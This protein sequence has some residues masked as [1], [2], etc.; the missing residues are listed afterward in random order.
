MD[1][2]EQLRAFDAIRTVKKNRSKY[3]NQRPA[4]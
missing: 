2:R 3:G 4:V 1:L